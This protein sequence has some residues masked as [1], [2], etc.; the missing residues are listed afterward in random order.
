M[1]PTSHGLEKLFSFPTSENGY[2]SMRQ[3]LSFLD[4]FSIG[5]SGLPPLTTMW[6]MVT[7][8]ASNGRTVIAYFA[9]PI[10][11]QKSPEVN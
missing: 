9:L 2:Q 5:E 10:L 1:S 3:G 8:L 6:N 4:V 11:A 7:E